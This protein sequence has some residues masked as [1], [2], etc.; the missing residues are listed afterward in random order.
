MR[1]HSGLFLREGTIRSIQ[2]DRRGCEHTC[3]SMCAL[4]LSQPILYAVWGFALNYRAVF[5]QDARDARYA[6]CARNVHVR[7]LE[8]GKHV[9]S[10]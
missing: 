7:T 1:I 4:W 8:R 9:R 10:L 2:A 5:S 3:A 6:P